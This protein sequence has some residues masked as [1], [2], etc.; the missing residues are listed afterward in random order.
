MTLVNEVQQ[1]R[2]RGRP[3]DAE[4][5]VAI[6]EA[7]WRVLADKG[8]EAF[9][10]EA[11]ADL[12]GCSRSTLYR[13]FANKAELVESALGETARLFEPVI[14]EVMAPRDVLIA[15]AMAMR[16][17]MADPRGPAMLSIT[18]SMPHHPEL[19]AAVQ[20]HQHREQAYYFREFERLCP[21]GIAPEKRDFAF[22]TLVGS[23]VFHV[24]VRRVEPSDR[25]I[26][27]LVDH[28][29]GLLQE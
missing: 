3:R 7:A 19:A 27:Q 20:R 15:H 21:A 5:D 6:L 26:A 14:D 1:P 13:R 10:F 9:T 17:Y 8:Y 29:I 28:A 24:A 22:Y 11:V 18:V 23:I 25:Q 12:A 4:K 16:T 2:G